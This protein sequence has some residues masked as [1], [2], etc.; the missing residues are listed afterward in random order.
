MIA[1]ASPAG[2]AVDVLG[3]VIGKGLGYVAQGGRRLMNFLRP[4]ADEIADAA[5]A[6]FGSIRPDVGDMRNV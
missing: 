4:A 1:G 3:N 6:G 5:T 2:Q